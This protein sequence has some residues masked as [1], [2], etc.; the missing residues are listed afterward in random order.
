VP[1]TIQTSPPAAAGFAR[2]KPLEPAGPRPD[3]REDHSW[4]LDGDRSTAYLFGGRDGEAVFDDLWAYDV[5]AGRWARIQ[6]E[7]DRPEARFGH[8]GTWVDGVGLVIWSGQ[9]GSEFFDDLWAFDPEVGSWRALPGRGDVPPARYGSCAALGPDG[10]LWISHG[11]T[12]EAGRFS[13]T[14]AYDLGTGQWTDETPQRE[15]PV[16]RCLHD[17]F[18]SPDG[19]FLLYAGQTTGVTALRDLWMLLPGGGETPTAWTELPEPAPPAR[20][21]YALA[22]LVDRAI[23]FG[24]TGADGAVLDDT[25]RFSF[26]DL[27]F[28]RLQVRGAAPPARAG[29]AL[30]APRDDRLLLFGGRTVDVALGDL[31]ALEPD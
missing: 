18:W 4:T 23:V 25:W 28:S 7:G 13:D 1:T 5:A 16:E 9:T 31:W 12:G 17:C 2:W 15:R 19:R 24:G 6:V 26:A 20:S 29:A 11:F 8:T 30:V 21:L 14:R 22:T 27:S 10:R 3:P